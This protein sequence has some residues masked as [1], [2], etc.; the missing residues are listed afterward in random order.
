MW[1]LLILGLRVPT[2]S[3]CVG[4]SD[5]RAES[6]HVIESRIMC[7]LVGT[8]APRT[9]SMFKTC[10]NPSIVDI[11]KRY[12]EFSIETT[13]P[14]RLILLPNGDQHSKL[15]FAYLENAKKLRSI[16]FMRPI[17]NLHVINVSNMGDK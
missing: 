12:F 5:P 3:I 1:V 2:S 10:L 7:V 15:M 14:R 13:Q 8:P 16:H 6:T 4:T 17:K 9:E 11:L